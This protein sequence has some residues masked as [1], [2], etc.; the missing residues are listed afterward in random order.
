MFMRVLSTE[1]TNPDS[2]SDQLADKDYRALADIRFQIRRFL[3]F[4]EIAARSEGVE[5]QQHQ[6]LLAVRALTAPDAP[7]VGQL[8]DYLS[9]RHHSAVGLTG[10]LAER[11]LVERLRGGADR[12]QVRI[13][14][15]QRGE[16]I[17]ARLSS[18]HR[19]ELLN[20]GPRLLDSLSVL[21][22]HP[23]ETS[24]TIKTAHLVASV[25]PR[26]AG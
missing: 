11:G 6:L 25:W 17:L 24:N 15:T 20:F 3:H 19:A 7:T 1:P 9:I 16:V 8:A 14:L 10:R 22:Q 23:R 2:P 5:P 18:A 21:L 12:R 13:Q 26:E 4:S